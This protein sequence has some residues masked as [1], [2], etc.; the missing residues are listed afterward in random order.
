ME[1]ETGY[2]DGGHLVV[3]EGF[4]G[5]RV[6][7][8]TGK[9]VEKEVKRKKVFMSPANLISSYFKPLTILYLIS[10]G[11]IVPLLSWQNNNYIGMAL[12]AAWLLYIGHLYKTSYSSIEVYCVQRM[13][14]KLFVKKIINLTATY[15]GF[16]IFIICVTGSFSPLWMALAIALISVSVWYREEPLLKSLG[17]EGD[18]ERFEGAHPDFLD[19]ISDKVELENKTLL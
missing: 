15:L 4:V 9:P 2:R 6:C 12:Y 16:M 17:R 8:V 3:R 18:Y 1:G 14:K 11:L 5:P 7:V 10:C 19:A 13:L